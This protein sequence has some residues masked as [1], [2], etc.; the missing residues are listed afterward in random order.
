[1]AGALRLGE[2]VDRTPERWRHVDIK[3]SLHSQTEP[4]KPQRGF[5]EGLKALACKALRVALQDDEPG[6]IRSEI[7]EVGVKLE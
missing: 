6:P 5:F 2:A 3:L 1:M 7:G 4:Y